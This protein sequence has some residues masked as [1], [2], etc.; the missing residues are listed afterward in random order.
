[1]ANLIDHP[2]RPST[3]IRRYTAECYDQ[4]RAAEQAG[5]VSCAAILRAVGHRTRELAD[6]IE[7]HY[8]QMVTDLIMAAID[9]RD[10]GGWMSENRDEAIAELTRCVNNLRQGRR[11]A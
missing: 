11:A 3:L 4:A 7:T 10:G 1:M 5:S 9:V 8:E 6:R 2:N